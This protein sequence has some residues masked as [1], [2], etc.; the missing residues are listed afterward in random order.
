MLDLR[1]PV[2]P[3]ADR[4]PSEIALLAAEDA[5]GLSSARDAPVAQSDLSIGFR[6]DVGI[7]LVS[8]VATSTEAVAPCALASLIDRIRTRDVSALSALHSA[9]GARLFAS[10]LRVIGRPELAHDAVSLALM[11]AWETA[12][13]FDGLRANVLTWL[14]MIVR[15]R[16]VD[17]LRQGRARARHECPL[18]DGELGEATAAS[19]PPCRVV[20]RSETQVDLRRAMAT[21]SPVQRQVLSLI[22]FEGRSHEEAAC[23]IGMPLGTLKSHARRGLTALRSH[24]ALS[25]AYG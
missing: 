8:R 9:C 6:P 20:E 5:A 24:A 16:A 22:Y 13:E 4:L 15:S 1:L 12:S 18:I 21:L 17:L 25:K 19:P 10:A 3:A 23:H 11:Q 2:A 14:L 7:T